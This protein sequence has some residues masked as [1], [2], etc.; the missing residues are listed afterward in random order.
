PTYM[1]PEQCSGDRDIDGRS[2]LYSLGAM[3]YQMLTGEPPFIGGST[4]AVMMKPVTEGPV[5]PRN[6]RAEN[7]RDPDLIVL[8]LLANDPA[9]RCATGE[10]MVAALDGAPVAPVAPT[11]LAASRVLDAQAL[12]NQ[13]RDAAIA[14]ARTRIETKMAR[15]ETKMAT[16][17]ARHEA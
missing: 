10:D 3:A 5:A 9:Q 8:K 4:P 2:D 17:Q 1:S 13:I 6:R 7:P 15:I 12:T 11:A 16:R 14:A